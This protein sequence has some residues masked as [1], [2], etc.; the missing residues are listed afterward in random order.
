MR[1]RG[2]LPAK[3]RQAR[4]RLAQLLHEK[5]LLIGSLVSMPRVCGKAG[6]RCSRGKLHP[7]LYLALRVGKKRK[8][9]H[10]PQALEAK[11]RQWVGT[12]QEIWGLME[13]VSEACY[14][15]FFQEKQQARGKRP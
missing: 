7:G 10:V 15:R 6:C 13:K 12:Y 11:V 14:Q 3:E 5:P 8:M 1:H 2:Y 9:V 4:S